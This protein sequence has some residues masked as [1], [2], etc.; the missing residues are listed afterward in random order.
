MGRPSS[1]KQT[2]ADAICERLAHGETLR[3]VCRDP[4]MP[5]KTTVLR[6]LDAHESFRAQY[7]RARSELA[8]HWA[9]EIVEIADDGTG[10]EW[11]DADGREHVNQ[12]HIQRSKLRVDARKW[13]LARMAP[14][15]YGDR[16]AHE[17]SGPGG[18]PVALALTDL[19]RSAT[20]PE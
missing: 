17:V 5:G 13:L 7:A 15:K 8:D 11:T 19:V 4:E 14:K 3:S 9:D 18:A 10:D 2:T 20:E 12:D 6:W 16:H 1:F